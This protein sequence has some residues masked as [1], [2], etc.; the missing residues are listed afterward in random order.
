MHG[1]KISV[2][3]SIL[4]QLQALS[5]APAFPA[6]PYSHIPASLA[7]SL[8]SS[9]FQGGRV[10][11]VS[12]IPF[13]FPGGVDS[14]KWRVGDRREEGEVHEN[15]LGCL[16]VGLIR[17]MQEIHF[18]S[19]VLTW[20]PAGMIVRRAEL[21]YLHEQGTERRKS[22]VRTGG[23]GRIY[24][25]SMWRRFEILN[26]GEPPALRRGA[27][28]FNAGMDKVRGRGKERGGVGVGPSGGWDGSGFVHSYIS[29]CISCC[30]SPPH[31]RRRLHFTSLHSTDT[32]M[33]TSM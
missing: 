13:A 14:G 18:L 29:S 8:Y 17:F 4:N 20:M 6:S 1:N 21:G 26:L 27:F 16:Q 9:L 23:G 15:G 30:I 28:Q 7:L 22:Y 10:T 3:H 19:K 12:S 11:S 25:M 5:T 24:S 2:P 32:N 31:P 33:Y